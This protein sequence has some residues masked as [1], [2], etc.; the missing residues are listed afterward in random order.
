M[1]EE[2]EYDLV[3][4]IRREMGLDTPEESLRGHNFLPAREINSIETAH[5]T[6]SLG[7]ALRN[8]AYGSQMAE[9]TSAFNGAAFVDS[10]INVDSILD[11]QFNDLSGSSVN[12]NTDYKITFEVKEALEKYRD[13]KAELARLVD[14]KK[15]LTD[16]SNAVIPLL[17]EL[18]EHHKK[19]YMQLLSHDTNKLFN[20]YEKAL[21]LELMA[22]RMEYEQ[23]ISRINTHM[24]TLQQA[25][26]VITQFIKEGVVGEVSEEDIERMK[27]P[28]K[29]AICIERKVTHVFNPCGHTVCSQCIDDTLTRC[30][31]CRR[32]I[33]TK[34]KI[35]FS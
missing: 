23:E 11:S 21:R 27:D 3:N 20:E 25:I 26:G 5:R 30:H 33:L 10:E 6:Y 17:R 29:C 19:L 9:Y 18:V 35:Y 28:N 24:C 12:C 7:V 34:I 15:E 31:L 14:Q 32:Q 8:E 2:T 16:K 4:T 13:M 22:K 1:S